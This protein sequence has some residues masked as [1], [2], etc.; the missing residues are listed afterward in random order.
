MRFAFLIPLLIVSICA[1]C[2]DG[3]SKSPAPSAKA[4]PEPQSPD[5][6]TDTV[7]IVSPEY[8][9]RRQVLDTTGKVQF[10]EERLVRVNAPVTGRIV[11]VLAHPGDVVE[12]GHRLLLLD[13]PDLGTAKSDY[14]KAVSDLER[15]EK[16]ATL[17][18]A[19][20]QAKAI[21]QKELREA[22]ND[23][24]K[25]MAERERAASRLRTL[26]VPDAQ[27]AEIAARTDT[28]TT[29]AVTASRGGI[30]VERNVIP[31]Q[32][33][34]YGQSDT[35]PTLFTIADLSAMWVL[36]DVYEPDVPKVRIGQTATVTLACCPNERY[37]GRV[38]Y[39][40]DSVDPQT[41]TVKVRVVV[42]N[43]GRA[44]KAEMFVKVVIL[45]GSARILT[46]P[47]SAIHRENG[48]TFVLIARG[49]DEY[50]RREV[51]VGVDLDGAVEVLDGVTPQD[52][53]VSTGSI[54]LKKTSK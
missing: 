20:F 19:L 41:R 34:A 35:P 49:K 52:H 11:E 32:V 1:A 14:A 18:R 48:E 45:T 36:A 16:A 21:A 44:L 24:R 12:A 4:T 15:S 26:G 50:D 46:L 13:S 3:S 54:L 31:G 8:R 37:E 53:V 10:N 22:E 25:S 6:A 38:T 7:K 30:V 47:Q 23:Y 29:I 17:A 27:F 39:I 28:T 5:A 42:P 2:S 33:V 43:R 51:K 40:S 9:T